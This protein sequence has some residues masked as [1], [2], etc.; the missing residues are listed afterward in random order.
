MI[1]IKK[2]NEIQEMHLVNYVI[3][4]AKELCLEGKPVAKQLRLYLNMFRFELRTVYMEI[5]CILI[6]TLEASFLKLIEEIP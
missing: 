2:Y 1:S 5:I 3:E 4:L 6:S